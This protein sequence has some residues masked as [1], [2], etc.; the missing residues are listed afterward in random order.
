MR[1]FFFIYKSCFI[2]QEMATAATGQGDTLT[3]GLLTSRLI[4]WQ[5][6]YVDM[7]GSFWLAGLVHAWIWQSF[8]IGWQRNTSICQHSDWLA[9]NRRRCN[10]SF[11]IGLRRVYVDLSDWLAKTSL[12]M[13]SF[14]R[15]AGRILPTTI[16]K[17]WWA[18]IGCRGRNGL[19]HWL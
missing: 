5:R 1:L 7:S 9:K 15:L 4:G 13:V 11:P 3:V 17:E 14:Y 19:P 8:L 10:S 2:L 16:G 12:D 18:L 6:L